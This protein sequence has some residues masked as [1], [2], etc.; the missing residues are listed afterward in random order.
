MSF[1]DNVV[2]VVMVVVGARLIADKHI[3]E[4]QLDRAVHHAQQMRA[5]APLPADGPERQPEEEPA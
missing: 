4:W 2:V 1:R 5:A 3:N